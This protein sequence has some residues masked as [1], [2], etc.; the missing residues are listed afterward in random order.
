MARS[1]SPFAVNSGERSSTEDRDSDGPPPE[2]VAVAL[3]YQPTDEDQAAAGEGCCRP[4]LSAD[5]RGSGAGCQRQRSRLSGGTDHR[6]GRRIRRSGAIR[7]G[8]GGALGGNG[9]RG[10]DTCGSVYR[11]RGNPALRLRTQWQKTAIPNRRLTSSATTSLH[12][13]KNLEPPP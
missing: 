3:S 7:F 9:S 6:N 10:R 2:K 4:L 5:G 13:R 1:K 12:N 8:S 11:R